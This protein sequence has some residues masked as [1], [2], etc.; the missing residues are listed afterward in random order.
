MKIKTKKTNFVFFY[1]MPLAIWVILFF[2]IPTI[3]IFIYSFFQKSLYGGIIWQFSL[4][5]Y[6]DVLNSNFLKITLT[7]LYISCMVTII[8]VF[9]AIPS[10]YY[11]ARSKYKNVL[12]F[13]IIVPFWTNFLI[14]IYAWIAILGNNGFVNNILL[15]FGM[16][17]KNIQFLY[18]P[19]AVVIITAYTYLPYAILP[20]YSTT[21]KFDFGLLEASR[22][23]GATKSQ[24]IFKIFIPSIKSGIVTAVI[25]TFIP[26]LGSYAIPQL[27]G[28]KNSLMLGNLIARELTIT[29]NWPLASSI[30]VLLTLITTV[31]IMIFL[32]RKS[33]L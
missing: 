23:L 32:R 33:E 18:N 3:T 26:T 15:N 29:R 7:T 30:S 1:T 28:G 22:D 31:G 24:S 6:K 2:L 21:E 17:T 14:R 20:L 5:A 13:L 4:D 25:F 10:A 12:L 9:L 16:I 8:T 19:Y 11:M 27:V